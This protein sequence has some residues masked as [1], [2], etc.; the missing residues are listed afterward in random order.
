MFR[1]KNFKVYKYAKEFAGFCE[2]AIKGIDRSR[3]YE[4]INQIRGAY[5][6]IILNIAE[7]SAC[8]SDAEFRRFLEI[9]LRSAYEVAAAFD[10]ALEMELI[11]D[12]IQ[13]EVESKAEELCK[14]LSGFRKTLK[15]L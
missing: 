9:S 4:L 14:Q 15:K 2:K 6:S 3:N 5:L 11:S 8:D 13:T 10:F 7:G 12:K 1:F